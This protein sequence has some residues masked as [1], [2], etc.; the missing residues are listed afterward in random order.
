MTSNGRVVLIVCTAIAGMTGLVAAAPSL[1][2]TFCRVTGFDGTTQR[3]DAGSDRV[4]DRKVT[5]RFDGTVA[6]GLPWSFKPEQVSQ[7]LH[8]GETAM[9]YFAATNSSDTPVVGTATFN[10]QPAKA[11]LYFMKVQCFCFTEQRLEPGQSVSMPVTYF[12]DPS[13]ADD[14]N[15][16]DVREITLSYTF[17]RNEDAEAKLVASGD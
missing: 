3:A 6:P 11:G 5:V 8:V 17:Y 13:I 15:L 1:Y 10:V 16:D 2:N 9:A 14:D 4:L 12:I 7:T